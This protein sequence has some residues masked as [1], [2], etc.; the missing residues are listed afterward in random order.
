MVI[1]DRQALR[2]LYV[3]F[4]RDLGHQVASAESAEQALDIL[5]KEQM[6]AVLCDYM[7]P[8]MSGLEL[9]EHLRS[10]EIDT[11]FLIM[12][13][14]GEIELAVACIKAGAFDFI[15]K[16]IDLDYL[17]MT[18]QKAL[19]LKKL[20]NENELHRSRTGKAVAIIGSSDVI[21]KTLD[22]TDRVAETT[23]TCLLL[24]ESGTG[25][26][27]FAERIHRK[28]S[29]SKGPFITINCA[30]IPKELLESELF[31]HEKGAFTGAVTRKKGLI[32][33][34]RGGT[35]F[36]DELGELPFELQ[37]KLLRVLQDKTFRPVGGTRTHRADVRFVC[38]TNR[39]L[40]REVERGTFREDLYFRL[41]VF[42]IEIPALRE[43]LDDLEE[44]LAYFI[45]RINN[46]CPLPEPEVLAILQTYAWP[47]NVRELENIVERAMLLSKGGQIQLGHLPE[48]LHVDAIPFR[49]KLDLDQSI[50]SNINRIGKQVEKSIIEGLWSRHGGNKTVI[51]Q[52]AGM[53]IKTLN[54]RLRQYF[55]DGIQ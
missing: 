19:E 13:A 44:L 8:G 45:K 26:E 29:F 30:S 18:I 54:Q 27:L 12:T 28:S 10:R 5:L 47:G 17:E 2:E 31:G 6:D 22:V 49:A 11:P 48:G 7:L 23:T 51:A 3:T 35:V 4:L 50:K 21:R 38:A 33:M 24:G 20:Q 9:V 16:P 55:P 25:K 39:D 53:S 37:P 52:H 42:P 32:E 36:L 34:A 41:S 46:Q 40:K 43:R 15:E 14:F 1:E